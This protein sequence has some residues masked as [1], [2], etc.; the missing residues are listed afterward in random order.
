[1]FPTATCAAG[2]F[3]T[4]GTSL[5]QDS[6]TL[7]APTYIAQPPLRDGWGRFLVYSVDNGRSQYNIRSNGR[8]GQTTGV[9]CGTTTDFNDDIL[10]TNG[11][12]VQW[13]EGTQ[14]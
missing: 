14:N 6:F 13:P 5:A 10:Y 3:T 7:L 9:N 2:I 12:F 11:T 4:L 8:D 1:M